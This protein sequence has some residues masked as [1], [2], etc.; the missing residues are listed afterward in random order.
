MSRLERIVEQRLEKLKKLQSQGINPYPNRYQRSHTNQEATALFTQH[1][2]EPEF[3][4]T[5]ELKLAG[6]I[7]ASRSMG[8]IAF[9]DIRDGSGKIQLFIS[10]EAVG[11]EKYQLLHDFD[12][13][14]FVGVTGTLIR[15]KT[16]EITLKVTDATLLSK[17]MHP[18]P[19][20]WH[21]LVDIEKRYR[22]R[23]LDLLSNE[24]A[25]PVF[26]RRGQIITALR[27]YLNK[28]GFLEV[29]TPVLQSMAGGAM[30]RPF[31]THHHALDQDFYLRI[32]LELYLKRLIVGG[33]DKVYE[34]GRVF[35]NE[36]IS[37]K[38]NPEFTM[39]ECYQAY[40]DYN[41]MMALVEDMVC[42]IA[43][44]VIGSTEVA[45]GSEQ[46]KLDKPWRRLSLREA[47]ITFGKVDFEE[48]TDIISLQEKM[49][50]MNMEVDPQKDRGKLIDELLSTFVEPHLIQPTFL[51]DYPVEMSPLAK[52]KP[53]TS[54]K[55]VERFE[56]FIGGIEVANS[57]TELNNPIE[58]EERFHHQLEKRA[59]VDSE[60]EVID[61]DFLL[62]LEYGMPPTGGLGVGIDRL[63]MLLTNQQS[64]RDVILFPQL[65][66]KQAE[67][68]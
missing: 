37:I 27:N 38:H 65:K 59:P 64:I 9:M 63:V 19:E 35:R 50:Q 62:A 8:K 26:I 21:G 67:R 12:I 10:R 47:L 4:A 54:G 28:Q 30:A 14:D 32:A 53:D 20:K 45:F 55:L 31:I 43:R 3:L 6:R 51:I 66:G 11:D 52:T 60:E 17:S 33:F 36:G 5:L 29:E 58:Q 48:Y 1:E 61:D 7:T 25:R 39:M 57:F 40:A 34:L 22:Q 2:K 24:E 23:Y 13:G 46:I 68:Q 56:A 44:D 16:S 18:L 15:T 49:K 41:D 42:T